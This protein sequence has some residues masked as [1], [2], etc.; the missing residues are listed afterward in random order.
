MTDNFVWTDELVKEYCATVYKRFINGDSTDILEEFK[1]LKLTKVKL[2]EILSFRHKILN[3]IDRISTQDHIDKIHC[4]I[5][6]P[7]Y[8]IFTV[9]SLNGYVFNL[10]CHTDKGR[11]YKF[12]IV[13][14][15]M[16]ASFTENMGFSNINFL[17]PRRNGTF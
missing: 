4:W 2:Y 10:N 17:K 9:K 11:I 13:G 15:E 8:E 3:T 14:N 12:Q 16:V 7:F 5:E 6:N 1:S